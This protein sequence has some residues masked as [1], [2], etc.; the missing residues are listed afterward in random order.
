[1][2]EGLPRRGS[3]YQ[4]ESRQESGG[5]VQGGLHRQTGY[6]KCCPGDTGWLV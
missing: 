3:E 2:Q 4:E 5:T 1:M 6:H